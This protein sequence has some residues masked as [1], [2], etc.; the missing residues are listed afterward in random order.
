LPFCK[1][2]II[3]VHDGVRP[4][5][6]NETLQLLFSAVDENKA[7]IP[8]ILPKESMR[9]VEGVTNSA[10]ER[11][12]YRVV[13]TPQVF[14]AELLRKAYEQPFTDFITDDASLVEQL[15]INIHL[16]KGNEE[17][18]KLTNPIDLVLGELIIKQQIS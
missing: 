8:V 5:V 16:V 3:A 13:Q 9:K 6:N 15:G 11:A 14:I 1:G 10:V 2:N 12:A 17:N 7:V 4:F 18:I